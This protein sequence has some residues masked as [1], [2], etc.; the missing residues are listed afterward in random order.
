M[1]EKL[2]LFELDLEF[3]LNSLTTGIYVCDSN[4]NVR[5]INQA[6]ADYLGFPR[7][8][9]EGR[10]ITDFIPDSRAPHVIAHG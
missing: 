6:Y 7:E 9:I 10:R 5:F 2:P 3:V 8:Q 1:S 4:L